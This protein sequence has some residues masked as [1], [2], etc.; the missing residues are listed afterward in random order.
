MQGLGLS[1]LPAVGL[2]LHEA[3]P[4]LPASET[5]CSVPALLPLPVSFPK[6]DTAFGASP[7]ATVTPQLVMHRGVSPHRG[8][9]QQLGGGFRARLARQTELGGCRGD[10]WLDLPCPLLPRVLGEDRALRPG[11]APA[12]RSLAWPRL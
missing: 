5:P 10:E 4:D 6:V 1:V 2:A 11:S 3:F 8:Q 7:G 9:E 12:P